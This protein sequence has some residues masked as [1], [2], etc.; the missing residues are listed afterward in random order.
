MPATTKTPQVPTETQAG[1]INK[2]FKKTC[3]Q[4]YKDRIQI[5]ARLGALEEV[6]AWISEA[7]G[8]FR[9]D[10]I[11]LYLNGNGSYVAK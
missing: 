3:I 8:T 10:E 1:E 4:N 6:G 9:S 7:Q 2:Y 5:S 11:K